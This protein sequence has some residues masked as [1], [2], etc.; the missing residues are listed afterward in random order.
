MTSFAAIYKNDIAAMSS[1][2]SSGSIDFASSPTPLCYAAMLVPTLMPLAKMDKR[3]VTV[4]FATNKS[5]RSN[6]LLS[7]VRM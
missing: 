4:R 3:L 2:I 1:L 5:K 6:F 7:T